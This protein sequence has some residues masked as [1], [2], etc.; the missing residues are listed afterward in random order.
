M[1]DIANATAKTRVFI[2]VEVDHTDGTTKSLEGRCY[3]VRWGS[4]INRKDWWCDLQFHNKP[5]QVSN[6]LSLDPLDQNST[7]NQD[8]SSAYKKLLSDWH[9]VRV[10]I[11]KDG[12]DPWALIFSG[13]AVRVPGAFQH[14]E[15][16]DNVAFT[17]VGEAH[18]YKALPR[19]SK[20]VYEGRD[21]AS[22]LASILGDSEFQSDRAHVV[23]VDDP[24]FYVT[25]YTT[26]EVTTFEAMQAAIKRTGYI[27][28]VR[29]HPSGTAFNDGS[30]LSASA[31]GFYLTLYDPLRVGGTVSAAESVLL[32]S[33]RTP[34]A[35][36]TGDYVSRVIELDIKDVRT[37]IEVDYMDSV[38]GRIRS[39]IVEDIA[40][41][42]LYGIP[43]GAGNRL[44]RPM[45]LVEQTNSYLDTEGEV[46]DYAYACLHDT[47]APIPDAVIELP[48]CWPNPEPHDLIRV[49]CDDYTI[50]IGVMSVEHYVG[51]DN[52]TGSTTIRGTIDKVIGERAYW[53]NQDMSEEERNRVRAEWMLG[54][55]SQLGGEEGWGEAEWGDG[56]GNDEKTVQNLA[57][58]SMTHEADDGHFVS[59][60]AASWK[61]CRQ[62]WFDHSEVWISIGNNAR[63]GVDPYSTTRKSH[64]MISPVPPGETIFVKVRH[65]PINTIDSTGNIGR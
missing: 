37:W 14:L 1:R 10:K 51:M 20:W 36:L 8:G 26:G 17:P 40:A 29:Y 28:A 41:Q 60:V 21:A 57:L 58:R 38:M 33:S 12:G 15:G 54:S 19:L 42:A 23:V 3:G 13:Y 46:T 30:G 50:E 45:R 39:V 44:H 56:W 48:Y 24:G 16:G 52:W 11:R 64:A 6:N 59:A 9:N 63:Y 53:I 22:L 5:E 62:W 7:L 2:D 65:M 61:P 31:D 35:T 55:M 4:D 18:P 25:E 47:S 43:D 49:V 32:Q 34:D 27:L